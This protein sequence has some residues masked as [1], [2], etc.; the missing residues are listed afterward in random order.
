MA[1]HVQHFFLSLL[2]FCDQRALCGAVHVVVSAFD[3]CKEE[4]G[5]ARSVCPFSRF[6]IPPPQIR[7]PGGQRRAGP[8]PSR[9]VG[10]MWPG[11]VVE[12]I[13]NDGFLS[14]SLFDL[15]IDHHQGVSTP[16]RVLPSSLLSA[17]PPPKF[18]LVPGLANARK[19]LEWAP[20]SQRKM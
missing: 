9:L 11:P 7:H 8:F 1:E 3:F 14:L 6:L 15:I 12:V 4:L 10:A 20:R 18:V 13:S 5:V 19:G 2:P 16:D 17:V